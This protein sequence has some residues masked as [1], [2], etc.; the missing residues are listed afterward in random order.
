MKSSFQRNLLIGFGI[1]MVLLIISSVAS[2][3]S[4][5]NLLNSSNYVQHTADIIQKLESTLSSLKDAET[6]Q[7]GYLASG[8]DHFLEPYKGAYEKAR[9]EVDGIRKMV[10]DNPKQLLNCD[11]LDTVIE[12]RLK[13]LD[14]LIVIKR[15][16]N[17][18]DIDELER[19]KVYMDNA[20]QMI[21]RMTGIEKKLL[22]ERTAE[23]NKFATNTPLLIIVAAILSLVITIVFFLRINNDFK[24][25]TELQNELQEK[26]KEITRRINIIQAISEKISNG[27]YATRVPEEGKDGLGVLS[28]SLN[29]MAGSL[30]ESFSLLSDKEWMQTGIAE[31]NVTMI[32]ETNM[33]SLLSKV[34]EYVARY[35]ESSVGAIYLKNN[36]EHLHFY[37]GFSFVADQTNETIKIGEG[38]AGQAVLTGKQMMLNNVKA[39]NIVVSYAAGKI[40]PTAIIAM[41]LFHENEVIG[42]MEFASLNEYTSNHI[43]YL[44]AVSHAIGTVIN[45][46]QTRKKLQELL[47]E[48]QAQSEELQAQHTEMES[49]N[50]ELEAQTH[51][52]QA[53]EEELKVQQEELSQSNAELEEKARL[54]EERNQLIV[55]RNMEIQSKAEQLALST[56]YKSEFLANMSHELRTPLNSILLLSRL[57]AENTEENLTEQQIEY[58]KVIQGSGNGLLALI[59]EILDL[60]KI[61]S[62]KMELEVGQVF[63][64]DII[65]EM[66]ALFEP[67]AQEKKLPFI[68]QLDEKV[69]AILETDKMRLEQVLKN[70]LSNALKFTSKGQVD[71]RIGMHNETTI[72]FTVKDTGIGVSEEKQQLIFEAFQQEDGSTRRK[73]GGTGLGLS[74]SR[75]LAKLLGGKIELE[76][77]SGEG[78]TFTLLVPID[79]N[80]IPVETKAAEEPIIEQPVHKEKS[81]EFISQWIPENI[82]DDRDSIKP[83]DRVLLIVEDDTAFAKSLIEYTRKQGYKAIS[84]VRGD[85]ALS[86]AIQYKPTGILL[87]IQLPVK[88]GLEVMDELKNNPATKHIPVHMM[89]SYEMKNKSLSKGAIDFISKPVAFEKMRD[90]FDK[91]EYVLKHS[92]QKVLIVEE[93]AKH[94]KALAYFLETYDVN[95]EVKNSITDGIKALQEKEVNCV[96]LDMGIP[97]QNSYDTLEQVKK[98]PGLENLP[99]I[100]FTGKSLSKGEEQRIKQYADTIVVKTAYSYQRIIDEVSLFLHLVEENNKPASTMQY[101]KLGMLND[102]LKD[103]KVLIADDDVRNIYSLTKSLENYGMNIISAIDGKEALQQLNDGNKVDIILMDMMMPEMDGYTSIQEIK[104]NPMFNKI[105]IIAVT[106]KAMVGDREKCIKAGASDYITKPVDIDQLLSLLRVWLYDARS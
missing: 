52:L 96:I 42:V 100:I 68:I 14:R 6:G 24:R 70:L 51:K 31:L 15:E 84:C 101:K 8:R 28:V 56:K 60:S 21:D 82:P 47:E 54:L 26:D 73:Y 66:K 87:D 74:I 86:M 78:S 34:V 46:V 12:K 30:E 104:K 2:F 16:Q 32:G 1:S 92:P 53:S 97:A 45:S 85:E 80:N 94:A 50:T 27:D 22:A 61:E 90:I 93:N 99:I 35:T 23:L 7:R 65:D 88:D 13:Q 57:M 67:I 10:S 91:L 62:G 72:A 48:T 33:Q 43:H 25:R 49:I 3:I 77:V 102:V 11:L 58:A 38:I 89:S 69:P 4:I 41:P 44:E 103:K 9:L 36:E 64:H 37:S 40:K 55:E 59:N 83:N 95:A 20:R 71:F 75:E 81:K 98:T 5:K 39:S 63:I 29:R 19:G 106:A 105:P 76:S 18:V 79:A 17:I